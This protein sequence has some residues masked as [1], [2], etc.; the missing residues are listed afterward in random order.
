MKRFTFLKSLFLVAM[1]AV[2]SVGVWGEELFSFTGTS[3]YATPPAENWTNEGTTEGGSYLKLEGG[4]VTSPEYAAHKNLVLTCKVATYGSGTNH[5][6]V[7]EILKNG[8]VDKTFYSVTPTSST[9]ISDNITIGQVDYSFQIRLSG[10]S[11]KGV[12]V[13]DFTL[14]GDISTTEPMIEVS[15]KNI[16]FGTVA[17]GFSSERNTIVTTANLTNN[18]TVSVTGDGFTVSPN[19][20]G[21]DGGSVT[22]TYTPTSTNVQSGTVTLTCGDLNQTVNLTG[23]GIIAE[24]YKKISSLEELTDGYYIILNT[25]ETTRRAMNNIH[26]GTYLAYTEVAPNGEVIANNDKTIVWKIETNGNGRTIYNEASA[27]YVSYSGSSNNVQV[28]DKVTSNNQRWNFTYSENEFLVQNVAVSERYLKYN[29]NNPRFAC[30]TSGQENIHLYKKETPDAPD[31]PTITTD[32]KEIAF[33]DV[34]VGTNMK[35]SIVVTGANLT[36]KITVAVEG[37]NFTANVQ[38]LE[39]EGGDIELTY[40]PTAAGSHTATLTLTSGETVASIAITG[41]AILAVP[42]AT[43]ATDVTASS[44]TANWGEV[45]GAEGYELAVYTKNIGEKELVQNGGFELADANKWITEDK[46][47]NTSIKE[48]VTSHTGNYCIDKSGDGTT[49]IEQTIDVEQGAEYIFSFWYNNYKA[50]N[51]NG[52]KNYSLSD[53]S[54]SSSHIEGGVPQ[55]LPAATEWTKYEKTF[56]ATGSQMKVS[57]RAYEACK[58]DDISLTKVGGSEILVS[59]PGYPQTVTGTSYNVTGLTAAT[60]YFYTVKA[61]VGEYTSAASNEIAATTLDKGPGTGIA[62]VEVGG[63]Y[64]A[65]G[66]IYFNAVAGQRVE[67][68]NT[69]GQRVYT[70]TTVDGLNRIDVEA[71]IVVVKIDQAAGK[72]V[73]K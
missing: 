55:K 9:Y 34:P 45:T 32:K 42:V 39:A 48:D 15:P 31:E 62:S 64:A 4:S 28:A 56:T 36:E 6:L 58:I 10:E 25:N 71:G 41:N 27:K 53:A 60:E 18:I 26:N 65:D 61:K 35:E 54:E 33:T 59:L 69:L 37:E 38:E 21:T 29:T 22:I 24:T 67:V 49:K 73:V 52:I 2:G 20:L 8:V 14:T 68:I 13:R 57:V 5:P 44:F 46:N 70:G 40:A 50:E 63:L 3:N 51:S 19:E 7:I 1:L 23:Q 16:D 43:E 17:M 72:V 12:R 47:T 66:A 11:G 30:Y